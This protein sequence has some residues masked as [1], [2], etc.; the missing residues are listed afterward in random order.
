M[1]RL[2]ILFFILLFLGGCSKQSW[3][4]KIYMVKAEDAFSKAHAM[5]VK[6]DKAAHNQRQQYYQ[7]ACDNF[8][9][10]YRWD[11]G[12]FT[13]NRIEEAAEACLRVEDAKD[14]QTFRE[15]EEEY[16]KNHPDEAKYGDAGAY[17]NLDG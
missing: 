1:K 16:I 17:M 6:K 9:K 12:A 3:L 5:R 13:L 7:V 11:S 14:E 4:A 10:A 15:F 2:S 8:S